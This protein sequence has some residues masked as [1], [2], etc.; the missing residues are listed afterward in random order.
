VKAF[1]RKLKPVYAGCYL[2]IFADKCTYLTRELA[3]EI[4]FAGVVTPL[5]KDSGWED[6]FEGVVV[7]DDYSF[8]EIRRSHPQ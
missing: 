4:D 6:I 2:L 5:F 3:H 1:V 7:C 8:F